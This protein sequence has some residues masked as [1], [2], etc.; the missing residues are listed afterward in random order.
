MPKRAEVKAR[1]C[2]GELVRAGARALPIGDRR[3]SVPVRSSWISLRPLRH[4][5]WAVSSWWSASRWEPS[6]SWNALKPMSTRPE[7]TKI[8]GESGDGE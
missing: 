2:Y 7:P 1:A 8:R 6:Y 5:R 3:Q 4:A